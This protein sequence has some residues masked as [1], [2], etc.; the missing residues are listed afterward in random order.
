[1]AIRRYPEEA[2]ETLSM[3][4]DGIKFLF[5]T[6]ELLWAKVS[7]FHGQKATASSATAAAL[8]RRAGFRFFALLL[9]FAIPISVPVRALLNPC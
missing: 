7:R 6:P 1:M 8:P 2:A 9:T 5:A 4:G 3:M